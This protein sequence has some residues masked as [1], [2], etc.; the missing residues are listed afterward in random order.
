MTDMLP[1]PP[2]VPA[3]IPVQPHVESGHWLITIIVAIV[4]A[5]V[6]GGGVYWYISQVAQSSQQILTQN[7]VQLQDQ[8]RQL[9]E[10]LS[11]KEQTV[12]QLTADKAALENA[13]PDTYKDWQTYTPDFSGVSF[14]FSFRYPKDWL[15]KESVGL[16]AK[17]TNGKN[18]YCVQF[19]ILRDTTL[20]MCFR[21]ISDSSATT[22]GLTGIESQ[23]VKVGVAIPFGG[24][25]ITEK[26]LFGS[27]GSVGTIIYAQNVKDDETKFP[28]RVKAGDFYFSAYAT[29]TA[30]SAEQQVLLDQIVGS[31]AF[32]PVP[33][34]PMAVQ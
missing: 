23:M 13:V 5:V 32:T 19:S 21:S 12:Q 20:Q 11:A 28:A 33:A 16:A 29:G 8:N 3:I 7:M 15:A 26:T 2:S 25:I 10:S 27:N 34:A 6:V 1:K 24:R 22:W 9:A 14:P 31:L 4:A 18:S 17:S 30:I